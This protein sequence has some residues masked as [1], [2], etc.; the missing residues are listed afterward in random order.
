M[1]R[2]PRLTRALAEL[3]RTVEGLEGYVKFGIVAFATDT[4]RWK[5]KLVPAN[6]I[7]K[8]SALDFIKKLEPLGG[9]SKIELQ[10]AGLA[11]SAN[12][13]AGKTN[14][15]GALSLALGI[16]EKGKSSREEY[17]SAVDTVFFLSDGRPT[18]GKYIDT[19]DILD[20]IVEA[21]RLRKVVLHTIAIGDFS[22]AFMEQLAGGNGGTF[23]DLGK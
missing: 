13:G 1:L 5:K 10:R 9:N 7:N 23:V 15:W 14:T 6:V 11:G 22:K 2:A 4:K 12:L 8:K 18:H 3:A 17:L 21:N 19:K 20:R 16:A